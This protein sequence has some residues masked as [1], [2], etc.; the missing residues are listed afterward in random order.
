MEKLRIPKLMNTCRY[1][2]EPFNA[3]RHHT[4]NIIVILFF[5]FCNPLYSQTDEIISLAFRD[6]ENFSITTS[7]GNRGPGKYYLL[8]TTDHWRGQ[9]FQLPEN[10]RSDSVLKA[11]SKNEHHPYNHSYIFKDQT[12]DELFSKSEKQYLYDES[13]KKKQRQL[14]KVPSGTTLLKSFKKAK[15]GFIFSITDPIFSSNKEFAFIDITVY[16]KE[17]E[18]DEL[19]EAAFGTTILIY[20]NKAGKGWT[21][22]RKID[23]LIL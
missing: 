1:K 2:H 3:V 7:L 12:L 5:F 11:L 23:H 6:S 21:R 4:K 8:S 15:N 20:E 14:T 19:N 17:N 16:Y 18:T 13:Q 9:R 22:I 10:L